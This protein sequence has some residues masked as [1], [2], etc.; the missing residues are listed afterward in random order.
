MTSQDLNIK[1]LKSE[2]CLES[3]FIL[4]PSNK[5]PNHKIK[6]KSCLFPNN[7]INRYELELNPNMLDHQLVK[8]G[9]ISILKFS[10]DE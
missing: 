2:Q 8:K 10:G 4:I 1:K 7:S 6:S 9:E 3:P 5:I